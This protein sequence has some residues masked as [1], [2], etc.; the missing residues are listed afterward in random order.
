MKTPKLEV[1][2]VYKNKYGQFTKVTDLKGGFVYFCGW[3]LKETEAAKR[4]TASG[5]QPLNVTAF[6]RLLDG[7]A[8]PAAAAA[9]TNGNDVSNERL[10]LLEQACELYAQK[11]GEDAR[12]SMW[13]GVSDED[14][15]AR[16]E[17]LEAMDDAEPQVQASDVVKAYAAENDIDLATVTGTGANGNIIK[18]D[19][20]AAI[21]AKAK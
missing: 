8:A 13:D 15:T 17:E 5:H 1:G 18:K 2:K 14:I 4:D 11:T 21:A 9:T 10:A 3:H 16:I 19:V 20:E 12:V 6:G 7:K